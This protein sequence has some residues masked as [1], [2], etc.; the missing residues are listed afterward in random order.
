M[1]IA[2]I[3]PNFDVKAS[4]GREDVLLRNCREEPFAIHGVRHENGL[5]RRM[6]EEIA[7]EVGSGV[8]YLHANTA[9]GRVRFRTD[10]PFVAI[11]AKMPTI[12]RMPHFALTGS[13]GFDLY[14]DGV[15]VKTFVPPYNMAGGYEGI[16]TFGDCRMR[17]ILINFPL[18]SLVAELFIGLTP[19]AAVAAPTPYRVAT[20]AVFYGSSVTQGGCASRPGG[21]YQAILSR[22]LDMDYVNLGFSGNAL[23]G[24]VIS[25]Y[26]ASLPMSVFFMDYDYNPPTNDHLEKTH[27]PMFLAV[28]AAHP[29]IPIIIMSRAKPRATLLPWEAGRLEII[30]RTYQNALARGDKN[31]YLIDGEALTTLCGNEGT[32]DGCHP[33]D[34]GFASMAR[35]LLAL[36]RQ[37]NILP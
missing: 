21:S 29:D 30:T 24:D 11:S 7:K 31:V 36:I 26:L 25:R 8:A 4:F 34:F 15:Y 16:F 17:D 35:A 28:R 14:V 27:E 20:P 1:E 5:F 9:G 13:A 33:T 23:G 18:Y 22:E 6:P 37:H 12:G 10:S 3:D 2:A 32:V 19:D